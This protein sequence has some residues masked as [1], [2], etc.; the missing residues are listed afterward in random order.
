MQTIFVT[1]IEQFSNFRGASTINLG[2]FPEIN[3]FGYYYY[4]YGFSFPTTVTIVG[5]KSLYKKNCGS[6]M[7]FYVSVYRMTQQKWAENY[8]TTLFIAT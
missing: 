8:D 7:N 3:L 2:I 6:A 4:I 1:L 5:K